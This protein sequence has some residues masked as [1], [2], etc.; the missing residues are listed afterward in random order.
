MDDM[1]K[2]RLL[3]ALGG[4]AI[5]PPGA[6]GTAEEQMASVR[7]TGAAIAEVVAAGHEVVIT[8]GN[9]P[10]VGN[11]LLQN[12]AG[13]GGSSPVP[14][15]PL[16]ICG[17]ESQGM[18]G[19]MIQQSLQNAL[20]A[21]GIRRPVATIITQVL[22]A[23]GDP[24]FQNPTKPIG[25]FCT[26][27]QAAELAKTPGY[28]LREQPRGG[29]RRVVPSP[30]PLGI[31]ELDAIRTLVEMG[32]LVVASGGGGI[33]VVANEPPAA[34]ALAPPPPASAALTSREDTPTSITGWL[35]VLAGVDAVIDKD[36]AGAR[37]ALDLGADVF[38]ILT[39]VSQVVLDYR[40]PGE[41]PLERLTVVEARRYL[42]EGQFA[43]G[44]MGPKVEAAVRFIEGGGEEAIISSLA[45]AAEALEGRSGTRIDRGEG[46]MVASAVGASTAASTAAN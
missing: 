30:E 38:L 39:D 34:S 29:W 16:D 5:L 11:I 33:P 15:M 2:R 27:E 24:A 40:R 43:P 1:R 19:Y 28:V 36:L 32:V 4:N 41:R 42:A 20:A 21:L 7:E 45:Q 26:A 25:P 9:G 31:V 46:I 44:S 8:H 22:V 12:E 17:A 14:A 6:R 23:A 10:Q 3:I 13:E 35:P 18:I 37:L